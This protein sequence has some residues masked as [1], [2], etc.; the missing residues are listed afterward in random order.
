MLVGPNITGH[1]LA[2]VELAQWIGST[3]QY[4]PRHPA[5]RR[6]A[7]KAYATLTEALAE[8]SPL[9]VGV[10]KDEI[11]VG[12]V[13]SRHP[14]IRTRIGP[15]L[16]ERGAIVLR[17]LHGVPLTEVSALVDILTMPP[18]TVFDRGGVLRLA[19]EAGFARVQLEELGHDV[20][21][22]EREAQRRRAKL[23]SFFK[24]VLLGLLARH[25]VDARIAEHL[26]ELL[27]H[28]DIAVT[29]LEE[30]PAGLAEAAAGLALMVRQEERRT[31]LP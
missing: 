16:H 13:P 24:E 10:L 22:E 11:L 7:D 5:A 2:L 21:A 15:C 31:G 23:R 12:G 29:I 30:D 14:T 28:P 27:E 6:L 19:M 9:V 4:G 25:V 8:A 20:T 18:Q 26:V 1:E 3:L 17:F